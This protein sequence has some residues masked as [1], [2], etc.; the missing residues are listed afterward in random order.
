MREDLLGERAKIMHPRFLIGRNRR[1]PNQRGKFAGG[2]TTREIHLEKSILA[3]QKTKGT[4]DVE[5]IRRVDCRNA[6]RIAFD[7]DRGRKTRDGGRTVEQRQ[8]RPHARVEPNAAQR[9]QQYQ[10]RQYA[11]KSPKPFTELVG[12]YGN[13]KQ[14]AEG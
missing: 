5:P 10:D 11:E 12:H 6:L 1:F 3:V 2:A 9:C 4:G 13:E 7:R 8:T 14:K